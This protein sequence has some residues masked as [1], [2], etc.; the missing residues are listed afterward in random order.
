MIFLQNMIPLRKTQGLVYCLLRVASW[1]SLL[2]LSVS[3]VSAG[4]KA[5]AYWGSFGERNGHI[6]GVFL[7]TAESGIFL[8]FD[9]ES[10][11]GAFSSEVEWN[12]EGS[13]VFGGIAKF[14][15]SNHLVPTSGVGRAL[16]QSSGVLLESGFK[17][18]EL[19]F[20]SFM[21]SNAEFDHYYL[22]GEINGELY[23][24]LGEDNLNYALFIDHAGSILGG[25]LQLDEVSGQLSFRSNRG[26]RFE[27]QT[28]TFAPRYRLA[29]GRKGGLLQRSIQLQS[30]NERESI[31]LGEVWNSFVKTGNSPADALHFI[32]EGEGELSVELT[33][34]LSI[35]LREN[36]DLEALNSI[37]IEL[38]RLDENDEWQMLFP[39]LP[40]LRY[41][42]PEQSEFKISSGGRLA[43]MLARGTYLASLSNISTLSAEVET[44][45]VFDPSNNI[46]ALNGSTFYHRESQ[47]LDHRFGFELAGEGIAQALV[48]SVGPGLNYFDVSECTGDPT[49][50]V[51]QRGFKSWKNEDWELSE[52][53]D[54]IAALGERLGAFPLPENSK[55]SALYLSL[56]PGSYQVESRRLSEDEGFEI[57]EL[58]LH[59]ENN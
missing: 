8:G 23:V 17:D 11:I 36:Y 20:E 1:I 44:R 54:Q 28:T 58:Y 29:D 24:I 34:N 46:G 41:K 45:A 37:A 59:T 21:K 43:T 15:D 25:L 55:D 19:R 26:D 16:D 40:L 3:T 10:E 13:F 33:A 57:I 35:D 32:I 38:Y 7:K 30:D 39:S 52:N 53:S 27:F 48:R 22:E 5:E 4:E 31:Y 14:R 50:S 2:F 18:S 42:S 9:E 56:G 6:E 12:S 49:L 47:N 51:Y